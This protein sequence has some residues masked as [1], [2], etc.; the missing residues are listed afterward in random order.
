MRTQEEI[1]TELETLDAERRASNGAFLERASTLRAELAAHDAPA[2]ELVPLS[3]DISGLPPVPERQDF[4]S[5]ADLLNQLDSAAKHADAGDPR[6]QEWLRQAYA[7][8]EAWE[9]EL[10]PPAVPTDLVGRHHGLIR[11]QP[12]EAKAPTE[13]QTLVNRPSESATGADSETR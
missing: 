4:D 12:S 11:P 5:P 10:H 7:V 9:L 2:L 8:A 1:H 13:P 6:A 3:V